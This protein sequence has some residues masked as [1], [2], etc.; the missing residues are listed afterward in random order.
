MYTQKIEF[1]CEVEVDDVIDNRIIFDIGQVYFYEDVYN[2]LYVTIEKE[3]TKDDIL[4]AYLYYY[5]EGYCDYVEHG[6]QVLDLD[7]DLKNYIVNACLLTYS[8][9]LIK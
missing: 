2:Y 1:I 6:V 7:E 5:D 9:W 4:N 3:L 8:E